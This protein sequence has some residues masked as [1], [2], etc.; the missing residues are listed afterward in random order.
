MRLLRLLNRIDWTQHA[1]SL[2]VTLTYPD[3]FISRPLSRR[4]Q[5][6]S[7]FLREVETHV[8]KKVSSLWRLEWKPRRTGNVV[9]ELMPHFHLVLFDVEFIPHAMVRHWWRTILGVADGPLA[10]DVQRPKTVDGVA[11]YIG[12]Y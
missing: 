10:T 12:K 2:F 5:D 3:E 7:R 8:G 11:R 9:G 4:T 1:R 6:R